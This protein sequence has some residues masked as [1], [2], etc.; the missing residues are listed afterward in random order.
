MQGIEA[1]R[2]KFRAGELR[3]TT[4][5]VSECI[6][7]DEAAHDAGADHIADAGKMVPLIDEADAIRKLLDEYAPFTT[8]DL[9]TRIAQLCLCIVPPTA[10]G[11]ARC[12]SCNGDDMQTP[13]AYPGEGKAGC[14][15]DKR[16]SAIYGV[17]G[18]A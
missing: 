9:Q 11:L 10:G 4:S 18:C 3:E 7:W 8:G 13:C 1:G 15:R 17:K 5:N 6:G 2:A 12:P 14:P 16:L